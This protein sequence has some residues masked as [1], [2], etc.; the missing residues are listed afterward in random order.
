MI[1]PNIKPESQKLLGIDIPGD[2]RYQVGTQNL[3]GIDIPGDER[4]QVRTQN[5]LGIDIER[6]DGRMDGRR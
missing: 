5:L 1:R 3:L 6:K 4:Y 2:K